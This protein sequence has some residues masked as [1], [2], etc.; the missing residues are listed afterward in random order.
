MNDKTRETEIQHMGTMA[1]S[2]NENQ[3][4]G[5]KKQ[6]EQMNKIIDLSPLFHSGMNQK[7]RAHI[8]TSNLCILVRF[9]NRTYLRAL[10]FGMEKRSQNYD[11]VHLIALF[12]LPWLWVSYFH[13]VSRSLILSL[14]PCVVSLFLA[15]YPSIS[16]NSIFS[17]YL[18]L[19]FSRVH[20][21]SEARV[22]WPCLLRNFF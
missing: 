2:K 7:A 5:K 13:S 18:L 4:G 22:D 8:L 3:N 11:F 15:L 10:Y 17:L 19:C 12:F 9:V 16:R 14:F 20:S 21:Q 6:N 1:E